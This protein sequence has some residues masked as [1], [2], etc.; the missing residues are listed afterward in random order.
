MR[1]LLNGDRNPSDIVNFPHL[2]DRDRQPF[3]LKFVAG[4]LQWTQVIFL[5]YRDRDR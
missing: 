5:N 1:S 3:I 2:I 4:T